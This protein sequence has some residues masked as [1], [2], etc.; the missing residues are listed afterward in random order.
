[1]LLREPDRQLF[2]KAAAA[3]QPGGWMCAQVKRSPLRRSGPRTLAGWKRTLR[4]HGFEDVSVHWHATS[5]DSPGRLVP[6]ASPTAVK[7][8]L[9]LHKGVRFGL[10][11]AVLARLALALRVFDVAVPEGTVTGRRPDSLAPE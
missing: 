9:S 5:L 7:D 6:V 2:E 8:T 4:R 11:K 10:A 3:V 1:M